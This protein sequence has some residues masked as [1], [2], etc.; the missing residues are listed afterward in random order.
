[1][2]N[3]VNEPTHVLGGVLDLVV[4]SFDFSVSECIIYPSEIYSDHS[5]IRI[6][7]PIKPGGSK[8]VKSMVRSWKRVNDIEFISLVSN[9]IV[10]KRC[11]TSNVDEALDLFNNELKIIVDKIAPFHL[12]DSR[13]DNVAPWFDDDCRQLKKRC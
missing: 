9:S 12:V 6:S 7:F 4:T 1:M 10:S 5:F 3:Q 11:Q 13:Q 8:R 2:V